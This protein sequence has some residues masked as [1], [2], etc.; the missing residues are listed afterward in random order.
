MIEAGS[1]M[2]RFRIQLA[3]TAKC[4]YVEVVKLL[5]SQKAHQTDR[6]GLPPSIWQRDMS[7]C[8]HTETPSVHEP[9][10][11]VQEEHS[12]AEWPANGRKVK[13]CEPLTRAIQKQHTL[14]E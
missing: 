10:I 14:L 4:E 9:S 7:V 13:D 5:L 3:L 6:N 8:C 12:V 11:A 1:C 2:V